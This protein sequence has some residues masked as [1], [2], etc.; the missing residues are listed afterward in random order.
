MIVVSLFVRNLF[1]T[2]E[3]DDCSVS[4]SCKMATGTKIRL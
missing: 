4:I 2:L 3:V 1:W